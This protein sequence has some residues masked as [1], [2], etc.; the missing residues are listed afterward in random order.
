MSVRD[1]VTTAVG[2]DV[3]V[4]ESTVVGA[5]LVAPAML[6]VAGVLVYPFV[7]AIRLSLLDIDSGAF[8]GA[9]HYAW[10]V[11][12]ANFWAFTVRTLGWTVGNLALQ[13]IVGV[14]VAMALNRKFFGRDTIRTA[15]L[16]PFVIPTAVTGILWRWLFNGSWG[17]INLLVGNQLGLVDSSITPFV[18]G[19]LA[20]AAVTV[21][22]AWRWTPLVALIVFAV[23]QTIPPEEY[24]AARIEGAGLL[25]EFRHVTYPHLSSA[26]SVLGLLG[27]LITFNIFD[28]IWLLTNGGPGT[29]TTTLPVFVYEV[30]FKR[31]AIG[32]GNATSVVLLAM[33]LVFVVGFFWR[34]EIV[35]RPGE[36]RTRTG[37]GESA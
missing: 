19:E 3:D 14:T 26:L 6:L 31:Q 27:F 11:S 12:Q 29:A 34:N 25:A 4:D 5:T 20:L 23:L 18:T 16:I 13:G 15:I 28:M 37:G 36:E 9:D 17:P 21:V 33:L 10:L 32:Q 2:A 24:E 30:T 7:G 1:R 8:V 22:N 35:E